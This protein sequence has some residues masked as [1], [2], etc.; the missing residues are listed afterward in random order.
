MPVIEADPVVVPAAAE[1]PLPEGQAVPAADVPDEGADQVVTSKIVVNPIDVVQGQAVGNPDEAGPVAPIRG[2]PRRARRAKA[3]KPKAAVTVASVD[4]ALGSATSAIGQAMQEL[5]DGAAAAAKASKTEAGREAN[6]PLDGAVRALGGA[7]RI[8]AGKHGSP[9]ARAAVAKAAAEA[10][11]KAKAK[12][13]LSRTTKTLVALSRVAQAHTTKSGHAAQVAHA[14]A[15]L[16]Q[17]ALLAAAQHQLKVA[18]KRHATLVAA[19]ETA[20]ALMEQLTAAYQAGSASKAS[21]KA[22]QKEHT[23]AAKAAA[24]AIVTVRAAQAE[25]DRLMPKA[26]K[27]PQ[28]P[29]NLITTLREARKSHG[30][31]R[32]ARDTSV[33]SDAALDRTGKAAHKAGQASTKTG[34]TASAPAVVDRNIYGPASLTMHGAMLGDTTQQQAAPLTSKRVQAERMKFHL[35]QAA[36]H[37]AEKAAV[38]AALEAAGMGAWKGPV[39]HKAAHKK[40]HTK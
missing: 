31:T 30:R 37:A 3:T 27:A 29:K 9:Q 8:A 21:L 26:P 25:V 16:E 4:D 20:T 38:D 17:D 28:V 13:E 39:Q 11:T 10:K 2:V 35:Y 36:A 19:S 22:A 6:R 23:S 40:A 12:A 7:I 14:A 34:Q 33:V 18:R 5:A 32:G 15:H 1:A 24:K